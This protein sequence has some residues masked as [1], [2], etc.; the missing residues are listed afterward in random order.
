MKNLIKTNQVKKTLILL[1]VALGLYSC[2]KGN[3]PQPSTKATQLS[4]GLK[5]TNASIPVMGTTRRA[6][7]PTM[8]AATGAVTTPVIKFTAG[9]ANIAKFKLE[10]KKGNT[11]IEVQTKNLM[12]VDL[13]AINPAV[14]TA[15]LDTGTYKELEIRVELAQTAD[16][17]KI[18]LT[19]KG[20]F[21][22]ADSTVVPIKFDINQN[23][24]IK[25]EANNIVL[26]NSTDLAS[27]VML[28]LD[29]VVAGITASDLNAAKRT[30]GVIVISS[31]SNINLFNKLKVNVENSG[32]TEVKEDHDSS[33][34]G[35]D[36]S[37]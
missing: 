8:N 13:F 2:Q 9:T 19:L 31:T 25:A 3:A 37:H 32:D 29:R 24:T 21:I 28:H 26:H 35:H 15:K 7:G 17:T 34:G 10:A 36:G 22:A 18:P 20:S 14:I 12:N 16:T 6:F 23:L 33:H 1:T 30:N 5:A 27:I 4:F 11:S